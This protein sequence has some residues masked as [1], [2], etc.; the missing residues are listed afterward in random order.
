MVKSPRQ[1]L[2]EGPGVRSFSGVTYTTSLPL[3][4]AATPTVD[5]RAVLVS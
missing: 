1:H 5:F 4:I 3:R 2:L